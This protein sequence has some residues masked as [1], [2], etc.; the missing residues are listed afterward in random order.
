MIIAR[1]DARA[2]LAASHGETQA[3]EEALW[4]LNAFAD[5]GADV[6]FLEAPRS[7]QEMARF[8]REVPGWRMANMLEG[9]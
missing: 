7:E 1:T 4:R 3:L 6:L 2:A 8:C 9:G 5:L